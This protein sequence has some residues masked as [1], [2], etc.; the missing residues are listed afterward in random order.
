MCWNTHASGLLPM[1]GTVP[2]TMYAYCGLGFLHIQQVALY[3]AGAVLK[4]H[5]KLQADLGDIEAF[6]RER[7]GHL[8]PGWTPGASDSGT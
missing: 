5:G 4:H 8:R 1:R 2:E 3:S 6:H 7:V